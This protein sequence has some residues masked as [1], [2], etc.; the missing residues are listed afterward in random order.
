MIGRKGRGDVWLS[1]ARWLLACLAAAGS[2]RAAPLAATERSAGSSVELVAAVAAA[3][4]GDVITLRPGIYRFTERLAVTRAGTG[5][6]RITLRAAEP[7]ATLLQSDTTELFLVRAPYWTFE[8][9][10][11]EGVCARHEDCEHAFHIVGPAHATMIRD[12]SLRDFNAAIKANGL[13]LEGR[14]VTPDRVIVEGSRL[15]NRSP[16]RTAS[17][18]TAVDVMEA[19]GW[20]VRRNIIADIAKDGGNGVSYLAFFKGGGRDGLFEANLGIGSLTHGGGARLGLSLGGGGSGH[21]VEQTNGAIRGNILMNFS[22]AAI[23]LNEAPGS[24]IDGNIIYNARY[25]IDVRF[26]STATITANIVSGPIVA[27][28]GGLVSVSTTLANVTDDLFRT[29]FEDP[30]RADFSLRAA[31]AGPATSPDLPAIVR[32]VCAARRGTFPGMASP[33]LPPDEICAAS[34]RHLFDAMRSAPSGWP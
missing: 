33:S 9:L 26:S 14:R 11:I 24:V 27:R 2:L 28:D 17:P 29:W 25:G 32:R 31:P 20:I 21:P 15:Y 18:V 5:R 1:T 19:S 8:G 7:E 10:E 34:A 13:T 23:Y 6:A 4:P 22:D 16:R 30:A 12:S 3:E